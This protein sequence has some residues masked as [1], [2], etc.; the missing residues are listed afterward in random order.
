M[1]EIRTHL[2]SSQTILSIISNININIGTEIAIGIN[3][4]IKQKLQTAAT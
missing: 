2:R 4:N 1:K 3:I